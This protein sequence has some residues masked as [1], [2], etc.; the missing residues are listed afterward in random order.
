MKSRTYYNFNIKPKW[1]GIIEYKSLAV[2]FVSLLIILS[3]SNW[4]NFSYKLTIIAIFSFIPFGSVILFC[5]TINES[6]LEI[7]MNVI[8]FYT[9]NKIYCKGYKLIK[10]QPVNF[11]KIYVKKVVKKVLQ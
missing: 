9:R 10:K 8:R 11:N 5:N 3:I 4:F 1:N 6:S 2:F 7:I